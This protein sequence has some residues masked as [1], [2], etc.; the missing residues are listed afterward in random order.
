MTQN[1]SEE[2]VERYD[3]FH[4]GGEWGAEQQASSM[5]AVPDGDYVLYEDYETL[6]RLLTDAEARNATARDAAVLRAIEVTLEKAAVT[7]RHA[8]LVQPDGGEPTDDE[9]MVCEEAE[10]RIRAIDKNAILKEI[11]HE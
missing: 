5:R 6:R 8:C 9:R 1:V 10:H 4:I 2:A 11:S 7:A 3:I